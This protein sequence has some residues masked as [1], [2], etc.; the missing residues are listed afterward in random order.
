MTVLRQGNSDEFQACEKQSPVFG[1][2]YRHPRKGPGPGEL[3]HGA[4]ELDAEGRALGRRV[5]ARGLHLGAP[6]G[7]S[8][9]GSNHRSKKSIRKK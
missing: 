4:G 8:S 6:N 5:A 9:W 7:L 2:G 3:R 1:K